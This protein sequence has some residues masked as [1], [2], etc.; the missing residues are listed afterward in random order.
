MAAQTKTIL[1]R[2]RSVKNTKKITKAMQM[3]AASKVRKLVTQT[4]EA[5]SYSHYSWSILTEVLRVLE[6][7]KLTKENGVQKSL[8]V[9][10]SSDKGLCGGY[11]TAIMRQ[12]SPIL[13]DTEKWDVVT[14]GK[15]GDQA[16]RRLGANI[17]ASFDLGE[18]IEVAEV[19]PIASML[20]DKFLAK[21]Y[22]KVMMVYTRYISALVQSVE[23][24]QIF[25]LQLLTNGITAENKIKNQN[26]LFEP[27]AEEIV[28]VMGQKIVNTKI[29]SF[30]LESHASEESARMLAMKNASEAATDMAEDLL[31][32]FNKVRQA[33]ITQEI[34]EISA[35][36]ASVS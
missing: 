14:I 27:N 16:I 34:S 23:T 5:R 22:G 26:F 19:I 31:L 24:A 28:K 13:K 1:T 11:N 10:V 15:K 6:K 9:M 33:A 7:N 8:L 30:L 21:K 25:P 2:I 20:T 32:Q 35:G 4:L 17:I 36:M 29:Y 3:V 12:I 18:K